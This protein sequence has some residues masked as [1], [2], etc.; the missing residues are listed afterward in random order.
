MKRDVVSSYILYFTWVTRW[1]SKQ[2]YWTTYL[3]HKERHRRLVLRFMQQ[4]HL[5]ICQFVVLFD[6]VLR[7]LLQQILVSVTRLLLEI[8]PYFL[9]GWFYD[10]VEHASCELIQ[11]LFSNQ[12]NSVACSEKNTPLYPFFATFGF[13]VYVF[14]RI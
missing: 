8:H 12:W 13:T 9:F 2:R 14:C 11:E 7:E 10:T 3:V 1:G 6:Q 4:L 5:N